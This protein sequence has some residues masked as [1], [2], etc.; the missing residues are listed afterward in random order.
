MNK[1]A[2]NVSVHIFVWMYVFY[3]PEYIPPKSGIAGLY[4]NYISLFEELENCFTVFFAG[5]L[6]YAKHWAQVHRALWPKKK[7]KNLETGWN[8][9]IEV[10]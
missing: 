2:I 6:S 7:K 9:R 1:A 10:V 5:H 8:Q 3:S 4:D